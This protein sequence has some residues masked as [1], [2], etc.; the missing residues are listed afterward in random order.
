MVAKDGSKKKI[1]IIV[2]IAL[3]LIV[4]IIAVILVIMNSGKKEDELGT[5]FFK[6]SNEKIVMSLGDDNYA[7][8]N[9]RAKQ[10]FEVFNV[11]DEE[12][13]SAYLYMEFENAEYANKALISEEITS[14]IEKG[15]Y[16]KGA[17]TDGVYLVLGL[18][19][20]TYTNISAS[21]LRQSVSNIENVVEHVK[22]ENENL[23]EDEYEYDPALVE[24]DGIT[25]ISNPEE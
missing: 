7:A 2:A 14:A 4:A 16:E 10:M 15:V 25:V 9:T 6:D 19:K 24:D 11:K 23:D 5:E 13:T 8:D 17:K 22:E 1:C 21:S 3:A 12:I 20:E 18:P